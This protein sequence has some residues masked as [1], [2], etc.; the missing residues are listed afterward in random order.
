MRLEV[1]GIEI[2]NGASASCRGALRPIAAYSRGA[3]LP[4]LNVMRRGMQALA[5]QSRWAGYRQIGSEIGFPTDE[6]EKIPAIWDVNLNVFSSLARIDV[7]DVL[8][9]ID[10]LEIA[11]RFRDV[12]GCRVGL[13]VPRGNVG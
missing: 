11:V 2:V 9:Q 10:R 3:V 5:V 1:P 12:G 6:I 13:R 8:T 7:K 4:I